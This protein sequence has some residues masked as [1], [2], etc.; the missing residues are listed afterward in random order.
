MLKKIVL[1]MLLFFSFGFAEEKKDYDLVETV[2]KDGKYYIK[3]TEKL[4]SGY[5]EYTSNKTGKVALEE[6]YKNGVIVQERQYYESGALKSIKRYADSELFL[7]EKFFE[8]GTLC[9]R[10]FYKDGS[11]RLVYVKNEDSEEIYTP[12]GRT[13]VCH[14]INGTIF[15]QDTKDDIFKESTGLYLKEYNRTELTEKNS[16][17]EFSFSRKWNYGILV[18]EDIYRYNENGKTTE[19]IYSCS[20]D[21]I[22]KKEDENSTREYFPNGN[23]KYENIVFW[24]KEG[25]RHYERRY[26]DESGKIISEE[27][28][29]NNET[30]KSDLENYKKYYEMTEG[31]KPYKILYPNGKTAYKKYFTDKNIKMEKYYTKEGILVFEQETYPEPY[32]IKIKYSFLES[33]DEY[34]G[35]IERDIKIVKRYTPKG[36]PVYIENFKDTKEYTIFEKTSY[37]KNGEIYYSEKETINKKLNDSAEIIYELKRYNENGNLEYFLI[38]DSQKRDEKHYDKKEN[39]CYET[40]IANENGI[41]GQEKETHI[42][43]YKNG[44]VR[45]ENIVEWNGNYTDILSEVERNYSINGDLK[46]EH[47][48]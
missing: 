12:E 45:K 39:L 14:N 32:K 3:G 41:A 7:E 4:Y 46:E 19:E 10:K 21:N 25:K 11:A 47:K 36:Q 8:D 9:E 16:T 27:I 33:W 28:E 38:L 30:I 22:V 40:V 17:D 23:K 37:H 42:I 44:K 15:K 1:A 13:K 35:K 31:D 34:K 43:Y 5:I 29:I 48:K 6:D 24:D 20:E 18:Y 2:L 26:Y